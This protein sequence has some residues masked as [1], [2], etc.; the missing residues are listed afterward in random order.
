MLRN[1][2]SFGPVK[3]IQ[4]N[5]NTSIRIYTCETSHRTWQVLGV[6]TRWTSDMKEIWRITG[7]IF[8]SR[9]HKQSNKAVLQ[10]IERGLN[11]L[12]SY[13]ETDTLR[14]TH[15][16]AM[17]VGIFCVDLFSQKTMSCV[18]TSKNSKWSKAWKESTPK[19]GK[20]F[21]FLPAMFRRRYFK[22]CGRPVCVN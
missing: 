13:K 11:S 16:G 9:S 20:R 7:I 18:V 8:N 15:T 10:L 12:S 21:Q 6:R 1:S 22:I 2:D 19:W 5:Q 14:N 17:E 4:G 3:M